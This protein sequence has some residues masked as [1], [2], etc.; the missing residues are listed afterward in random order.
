MTHVGKGMSDFDWSI[1]VGGSGDDRG[2]ALI[3]NGNS[4]AIVTGH[5]SGTASFGSLSLTSTGGSG[6]HCTWNRL[7]NVACASHD[8]VL[9][10]CVC[11]L[12]YAP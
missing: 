10:M 3:S 12:W 11:C 5:Y 1:V 8:C 9:L 6:A 2:H 7:H 4:G